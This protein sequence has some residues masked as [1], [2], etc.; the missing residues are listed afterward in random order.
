MQ[1]S[2]ILGN[3]NATYVSDAGLGAF[4]PRPNK[5]K[6]WAKAL[7]M[8]QEEMDS[9][10]FEA[11]QLF[12]FNSSFLAANSLFACLCNLKSL[13]IFCTFSLVLSSSAK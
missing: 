8:T 5:H 6:K 4:V 1:V 12:E 9:N 7:G 2:K 13:T 10:K 3:R 11:D